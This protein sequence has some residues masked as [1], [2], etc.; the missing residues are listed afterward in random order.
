MH[1][2]LRRF[3]TKTVCM[4]KVRNMHT[5]CFC[6]IYTAVCMPEVH[7]HHQLP[8]SRRVRMWKAVLLPT[9]CYFARQLD[10]Q[11]HTRIQPCVAPQLASSI[12]YNRDTLGSVVEAVLPNPYRWTHSI[13]F[14]N[15]TRTAVILCN[16]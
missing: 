8:L 16:H 12:L 6:Q 9:L 11:V 13:I 4:H 5:H 15:T 10:V 14:P 3:M 2:T 7:Y 1:K